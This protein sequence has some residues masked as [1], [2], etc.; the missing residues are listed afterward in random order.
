MGA[1]GD[2]IKEVQQIWIRLE[3]PTHSVFPLG[4]VEVF[5]REEAFGDGRLGERTAAK[6][7]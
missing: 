4:E 7:L 3:E 5:E 6:K 1:E 2:T